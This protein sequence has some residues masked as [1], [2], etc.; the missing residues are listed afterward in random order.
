MI[1]MNKSLLV[2]LLVLSAWGAVEVE[3]TKATRSE[4]AALSPEE[5]PKARATR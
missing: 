1:K 4:A 3:I 5:V 2:P